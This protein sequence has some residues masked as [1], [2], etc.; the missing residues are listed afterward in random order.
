M[1]LILIM[2]RL[3]GT[4]HVTRTPITGEIKYRL[5]NNLQCAITDGKHSSCVVICL[6]INVSS[7]AYS[8][9]KGGFIKV[10]LS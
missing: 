4:T 7:H 10:V 6:T 3:T 5:L 2:A 8:D 9:T 1:C